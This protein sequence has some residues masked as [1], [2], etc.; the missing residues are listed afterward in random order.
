LPPINTVGSHW[1]VIAALNGN[2]GPGWGAPEDGLGIWCAEHVAVILSP[3]TAA[4][5][6]IVVTLPFAHVCQFGVG[7]FRP[8]HKFGTV[9]ITLS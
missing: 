8:G 6:P 4:G 3:S 1:V 9:R 5:V 7:Q 2:G